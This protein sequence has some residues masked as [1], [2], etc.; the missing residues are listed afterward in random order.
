[1]FVNI[2]A[3]TGN[4]KYLVL[5]CK[6]LDEFVLGQLAKRIDPIPGS[7]HI[8]TPRWEDPDAKRGEITTSPSR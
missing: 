4:K 2:Y 5:S 6:F 1:M 7:I 3:L 8:E